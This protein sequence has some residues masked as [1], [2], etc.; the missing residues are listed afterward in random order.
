MTCCNCCYYYNIMSMCNTSPIAQ[1]STCTR[2]TRPTT[3]ERP[4]TFLQHDHLL[5]QRVQQFRQ[6]LHVVV[7][8]EHFGLSENHTSP[9]TSTSHVNTTRQHHTS[10][11]HV[12]TTRHHHTS[13]PHVSITCQHH[14][15]TSHVNT[16][17]QHHTSTPHVTTTRHH[18]T[19]T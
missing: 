11:S 10:P 15:S 18:H 14:T 16:T 13:P 3:Q 2:G 19:S 4:A 5:A 12:N 8:Q 6:L 9:H 1:R 7:L 17:R